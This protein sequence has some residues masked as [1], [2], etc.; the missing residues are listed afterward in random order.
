MGLRQRQ[1]AEFKMVSWLRLCEEVRSTRTTSGPV[2][3]LMRQISK[4]KDSE[5]VQRRGVFKDT[6]A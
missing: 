5:K 1:V 2:R 4:P 6:I 3:E